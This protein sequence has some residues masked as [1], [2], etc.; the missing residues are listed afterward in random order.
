MTSIIQSVFICKVQI[1]FSC[2]L[3]PPPHNHLLSAALAV[4]GFFGLCPRGT[5]HRGRTRPPSV[6]LCFSTFL[7][8]DISQPE[9]KDAAS[10]GPA[11]SRPLPRPRQSGWRTLAGVGSPP[12]PSPSAPTMQS[13][14][15]FTL[16]MLFCSIN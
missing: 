9:G 13:K 16:H 11:P 15:C 5:V 7:L 3:H 12:P 8:P 2:E 14:G 6:F 4:C 1:V 10:T